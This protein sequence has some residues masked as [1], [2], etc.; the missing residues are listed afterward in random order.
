MSSARTTL[1]PTG[2]AFSVEDTYFPPAAD[3]TT[4]GWP[5]DLVTLL[6]A[7]GGYDGYDTVNMPPGPAVMDGPMR[8]S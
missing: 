7:T 2:L 1:I 4:Y 5:A 6:D 3:P 8:S